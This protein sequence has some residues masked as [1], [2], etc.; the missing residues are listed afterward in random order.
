MFN[1]H[2]PA[3]RFPPNCTHRC[4]K[5][6][7]RTSLPRR[8][9]DKQA[10]KTKRGQRNYLY[11]CWAELSSVLFQA[12]QRHFPHHHRLLL[13]VMLS[14]V[15]M[16]YLVY[17]WFKWIQVPS[18]T[19]AIIPPAENNNKWEIERFMEQDPNTRSRTR[20]EG[21]HVCWIWGGVRAVTDCRATE[22]Q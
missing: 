19:P 7:P 18:P 11:C 10:S 21:G 6:P 4:N 15:T 17:V 2:P 12:L 5:A 22:G 8:T 1:K 20:R 14:S 13:Y 9:S 16:M 3:P